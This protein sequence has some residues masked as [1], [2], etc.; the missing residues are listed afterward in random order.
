MHQSS[1]NPPL[2][3]KIAIL[4]FILGCLLS[5]ARIVKDAPVPTHL[6]TDDIAKRSDERFAAV[7]AK[8]PQQGVVGYVGETGDLAIADYY[9]AQYA[10]APVV[11]D[12]S[13]RHPLVVGNFPNSIPV[14]FPSDLQL[15]RDFGNGVLIFADKDAK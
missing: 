3:S 7:K 9:L 1:A 11:V 15:V 6:V 13:R 14:H 12:H 10:L 8:L 4:I 2:K 5:S